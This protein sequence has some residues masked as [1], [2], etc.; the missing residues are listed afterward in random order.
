MERTVMMRRTETGLVPA[1]RDAREALAKI[2]PGKQVLV[3]VH[4][5]RNPAHHRLLWAL[6]TKT[7]E[8]GAPF[9]TPDALLVALKLA[10]GYADVVRL[11]T[12][13]TVPVPRSISFVSM[14]QEDFRGFFDAAV[15]L[16]C[17]RVLPGCDR[18]ALVTEVQAMIQPR[19]AA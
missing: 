18:A 16:I 17:Q 11:P 9:P 2:A 4:S 19:S 8:A 15:D 7:V 13:A 14:S 3:K 5:A 6:L 10:L 12:G 1:S